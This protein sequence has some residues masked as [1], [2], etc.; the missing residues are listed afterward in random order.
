MPLFEFQ[1]RDTT[2]KLITGKRFSLSADNISMQLFKEGIIPV[3]IKPIKSGATFWKILND[4][5]QGGKIT[6]EEMGMFA[7]QMATLCKTGVPI[8]IAIKRLAENAR[9]FR[10]T[11]SLH[12]IVEKLETGSDLAV[13][14]QQYPKV[15]T[16]LM[17]S[18]IKVGQNTGRLDEAFLRLNQ[19]IELEA[20]AMKRVATAMRYPAFVFMTVIAAV[21]LVNAF[22]IPTF[23]KVFEQ[24]HVKL[25]WMTLV[26]INI[27]SFVNQYWILI[28]TVTFALIGVLIYYLK[29]PEGKFLWD[30]YQLKIPIIGSILNRIILLRF[31]QTFGVVVNSGVSLLEGITLTA[32]AVNNTYAAQEILSMRDAIQRGNSLTQAATMIH[33]FTPLEIQMLAVSEDTGELGAMMEQMGIFYRGEVEYDLKRLN[34]IIEPLLIVALSFIVLLL[35][36]AVYM[37]IW[38]M[39]KLAHTS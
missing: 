24:A 12:G 1:A 20:S 30:K 36:L 25:P 3:Q 21:F 32:T 28:V 38:D 10:L 31:S 27:S 5:S 14:M 29:T 22:V 2:G 16:P 19:Y 6:T 8:T 39:I 9:S 37:P 7:R 34:D 15:F 11:E 18:I 4:L 35:A 13:A 17:V 23:A 26:L 33:F